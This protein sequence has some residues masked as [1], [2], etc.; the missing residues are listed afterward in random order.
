M[1]TKLSNIRSIAAVG[2]MAA[3]LEC[4]KIILSFLPN[5]EVVSLL[6]A[7]YG[8]IFGWAGVVATLVFV[9]IEPLIWGFGPW[10]ITYLIYWPLLAMLFML[11]RRLK[12]DN[13]I[14]FTAVALGMTLLFGVLSSIVDVA[15]YIGVNKHY[16]SNLVIYYI[17]GIGF[18]LAQLACNAVLFSLIFVPLRDR[19]ILIKGK[20]M[21]E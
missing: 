21:I 9:M 20:L 3:T 10:F 14:V 16:F 5:I 12:I 11:L 18:Y 19:L 1:S 4:G 8:Y 6:T 7:I 17:R 2:V 13:R 15:L